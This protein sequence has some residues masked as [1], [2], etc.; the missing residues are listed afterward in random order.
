[1]SVE[2]MKLARNFIKFNTG[3]SHYVIEQLDQAIAQAEKQERGE[4]VDLSSFLCGYAQIKDGQYKFANMRTV[5][6]LTKDEFG[7]IYAI[8]EELIDSLYTHPPKQSEEL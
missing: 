3:S 4:P 1:M 5:E 6:L 7:P 2:A 8:P